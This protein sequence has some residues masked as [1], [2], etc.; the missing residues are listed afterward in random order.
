MKLFFG[1]IFSHGIKTVRALGINEW[2]LNEGRADSF[3]VY[4]VEED[5]L[6]IVKDLGLT[7]RDSNLWA[8]KEKMDDLETFSNEK[9]ENIAAEFLRKSYR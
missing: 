5:H 4:Y 1:Y 9:I 3:T 2:A 8:I 7:E 6:D